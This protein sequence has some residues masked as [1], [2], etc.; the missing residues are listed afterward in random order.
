MDLTSRPKEYDVQRGHDAPDE[1]DH[2]SA[3]KYA[4]DF[5]TIVS[6][7]TWKRYL[8]EDFRLYELAQR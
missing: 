7:A 4:T 3:A 6:A 1:D 8:R 5:P 2:S